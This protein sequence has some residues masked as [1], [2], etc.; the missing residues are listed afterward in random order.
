MQRFL[1]TRHDIKEENIT[2]LILFS[3]HRKE[4]S[5]YQLYAKFYKPESKQ[6]TKPPSQHL[7]EDLT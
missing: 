6:I 1:L 2:A 3:F 7:S 5:N 4:I